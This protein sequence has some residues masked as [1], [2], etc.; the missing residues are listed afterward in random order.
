MKRTQLIAVLGLLSACSRSGAQERPAEA[1]VPVRVE[2]VDRTPA[3]EPLLVPGLVQPRDTYDLGFPIGGVIREVAFE[4][5]DAIDRNAILARLDP[6]VARAGLTQARENLER[7]ERDL[8]RT[9]TLTERGSLASATFEDVETGAD[10]ARASVS[11]AGFALRWT[12]LRAPAPGWVDARLVEP[13]EVVG[14]GQP[15]FRIASRERGFVLRV[16]VSDRYVAALRRG[17][18]ATIRLDA[19]EGEI[20]ATVVEIA[21]APSFATGTFDVELAFEPPDGLEPRTGLVGRATLSIGE[22]VAAS[23]PMAAL[24][25]GR[26]RDASIFV[27][28]DGRAKRRAVRVA[29]FDRERAAIAS[30]LDGVDAVITAGADRIGDGTLVAVEEH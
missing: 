16:S 19:H 20:A 8:A 29:F 5:G 12:S 7:A 10:V 23:V 2:A 26:D 28:E 21:R 6:T 1:A 25:D 30:G 9:R 3:S 4:E 15:V 11:S 22:P 17:D 14:A 18:R 13:G 24:V 27:I